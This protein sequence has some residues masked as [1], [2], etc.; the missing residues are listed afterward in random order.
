[1]WRRDLVA[2]GLHANR[3]MMKFV[4]R[5]DESTFGSVIADPLTN[6]ARPKSNDDT[7]EFMPW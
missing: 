3:K 2:A 5:S 1:M 4:A 6:R 7:A